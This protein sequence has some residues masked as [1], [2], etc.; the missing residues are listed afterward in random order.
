MCNKTIEVFYSV[1]NNAYK[2]LQIET[3]DIM[4]ITN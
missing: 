2:K 3:E 1:I 4:V